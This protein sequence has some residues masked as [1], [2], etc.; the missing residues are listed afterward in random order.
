MA[1]FPAT[2]SPSGLRAKEVISSFVMCSVPA[3]LCLTSFY[4]EV[5]LA[6]KRV[7]GMQQ[8]N[9]SVLVR[10]VNAACHRLDYRLVGNGVKSEKD[11]RGIN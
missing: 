7:R 3:L 4:T 1:L 10:W 8:E 9:D 11:E 2:Y 5:R 6:H